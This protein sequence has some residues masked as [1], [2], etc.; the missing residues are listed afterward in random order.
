MIIENKFK[1]P[2]FAI[3]QK[4][5]KKN[6]KLMELLSFKVKAMCVQSARFWPSSQLLATCGYLHPLKSKSNEFLFILV[7]FTK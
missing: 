5:F 2:M 3:L 4:I 6:L 1:A 7:H